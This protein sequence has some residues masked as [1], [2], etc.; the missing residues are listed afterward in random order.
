MYQIINSQ[1]LEK[2]YKNNDSQFMPEYILNELAHNKFE[3]DQSKADLIAD[4]KISNITK[5]NMLYESM[6]D[7]CFVFTGT[8]ED[9]Q[10]IQEW[11]Q[12]VRDMIYTNKPTKLYV[13]N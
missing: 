13:N 6:N 11:L 7:Q 2:F 5:F 3:A 10:L 9:F 12:I 4:L 1:G 8:S